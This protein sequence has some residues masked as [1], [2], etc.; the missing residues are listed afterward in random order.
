MNVMFVVCVQLLSARCTAPSTSLSGLI[1]GE[2]EVSEVE[3]AIRIVFAGHFICRSGAAVVG[4]NDD[5]RLD[6]TNASIAMN[7]RIGFRRRICE[8]GV[9]KF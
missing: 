5:G 3:S 8:Q 2:G 7:A 6:A 9:G 4:S 1:A